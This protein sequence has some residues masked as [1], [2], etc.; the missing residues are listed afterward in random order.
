MGGIDLSEGD[1]LDPEAG[2]RHYTEMPGSRAEN[3]E[4]SILRM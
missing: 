2:V 4:A 1:G 3:M